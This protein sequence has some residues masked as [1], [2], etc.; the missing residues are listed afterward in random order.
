MNAKRAILWILLGLIL[1]AG[2]TVILYYLFVVR[3][4]PDEP[5]ALT[6]TPI[7]FSVGTE[8]IIGFRMENRLFDFG[9]IPA[10]GIA[11]KSFN[12]TQ[13]FPRPVWVVLHVEGDDFVSVY[14]ERA[15]VAPGEVVEGYL[16]VK[17][18]SNVTLGDH[19]G[20]LVTIFYAAT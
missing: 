8:T 19:N 5:L 15:R 13:Q 10:G 11:R 7:A 12:V 6:R 1:T 18:P 4:L 20:T 16:Q 14:P 17:P 2:A 9:Q 3:P